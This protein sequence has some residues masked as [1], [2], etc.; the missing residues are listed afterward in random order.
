MKSV[1]VVLFALA[2]LPFNV[3]SAGQS[4]QANSAATISAT[5]EL[6]MVPVQVKGHDGRPVLGLKAQDFLLRSDRQ[7]QPITVFEEWQ[8]PAQTPAP[9]PKPRAD[10]PDAKFFSVP[11]SGMPQQLLII[12]IDLV[13]TPF[14]EQGRAKQ[15]LLQYLSEDLPGHP[16]AL[17]AI[18]KDGLAPIHSFSSD[19]KVLADA[20]RRM[21]ISLSKDEIQETAI[22][23]TGDNDYADLENAFRQTQIY[24]TFAAKIAA[25]ATLTGLQQIGQAYAGVPGRKSV[26][27]L[28]AGIPTLLADPIAGG[29]RGNSLLN[30]DPEL[31][32][33]FNRTF[34]AL[35]TAN[36]AVYAVDLKGLKSDKTYL[37]KGGNQSTWNPARDPHRIYGGK[38]IPITDDQDDGI[39]VLAAQ[40]GGRS[41][42][43]MTELKTCIDE[44]VA[45]STSYYLLGFYVPQQDRKPGWHKLEVKLTSG[46]SSVRSRSNYY[47]APQTPPNEKELDASIRDA[48]NAKI[49]Y[50]GFAFSIERISDAV[51]GSDAARLKV[52]VPASSVLLASGQQQTLS[53]DVAM[54]PLSAKGELTRN[55]RVTHLNLTAQQTQVAFAKGWM[56]TEPSPPAGS[57]A[58][59]KYV[60]RDNGTGRI[61][62]V[63]VPL[64]KSATGG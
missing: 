51:H 43:A 27:W 18:T 7:V 50:T 5:T 29:A 26:I 10:S 21:Q 32:A 23:I 52:V 2:L 8:A 58:A 47:L 44:A 41:C 22:D 4:N 64:P 36:I 35:N 28:T 63:I 14:L 55:I 11:E 24:G 45:D 25:R 46:G 19:P 6:V 30:A 12:A 38:T 33:D 42:T 9:A 13:N 56:F 31:L 57:A 3:A 61:G 20:L 49:G 17:V 48:A 34:T 39:K 62:S 59:V 60:I 16:F 53:Y 1:T 54:A 40:T 37:G 15:Q